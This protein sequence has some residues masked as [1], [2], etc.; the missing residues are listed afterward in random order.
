VFYGHSQGATHGSLALAYTSL[1]KAAVL[2]GNGASLMHAL[3]S[4]KS[5]VNVAGAVP[6]A[7]GDFDGKELNGGDMHPALT[8]LQHWIDQ[9]D[10]LNF[11][12]SASGV[13]EPNQTPKHVFQTYGLGDTYSPKV[14]LETYALAAG[15]EVAQHHASVTQPDPIGALAPKALPLS[16]NVTLT[17]GRV[18][19]A[20]RQYA[21]P[22]GKDGHFVAFDV[23]DATRDVARFLAM[24]ASG[25][26]PQVGP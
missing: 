25:S 23:P 16:G 18:T 26:V 1:Y 13:P 24:A 15:L 22:S 21:P 6:I 10:P 19:L 2:S 9:A 12:R 4:K 20:V 7:L 3:L 14:T 17:S 11:A 8:L 5:P